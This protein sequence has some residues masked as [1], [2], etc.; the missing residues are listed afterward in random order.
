MFS[1]LTCC[2]FNLFSIFHFSWSGRDF[3]FPLL[4]DF[5]FLV[6]VNFST[7]FSRFWIFRRMFLYLCGRA[8]ERGSKLT[9][10]HYYWVVSVRRLGW[11]QRKLK[12]IQTELETS[13]LTTCLRFIFLKFTYFHHKINAFKKEDKIPKIITRSNLEFLKYKIINMP[14]KYFLAV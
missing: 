7:N 6:G 8:C 3:R 5:Y 14:G 9:R 11:R 10:V 1:R 13:I 12:I 2:I 4:I